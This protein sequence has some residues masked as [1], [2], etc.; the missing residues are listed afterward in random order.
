MASAAPGNANPL[1]LKSLTHKELVQ[2]IA[3]H[4]TDERAWREF[5]QRYHRP[6]VLSVGKAVRIVG[7]PEGFG[8]VEDLAQEVYKK[9]IEKN[10]H[11]LHVFKSEQEDGI[12]MYLKVIAIRVVLSDI[13]RKKAKKRPPPN[14][15]PPEGFDPPDDNWLREMEL[16]DLVDDVDLC[17]KKILQDSR[18]AERDMLLMSFF[19]YEQLR[20]AEIVSAL[21]LELSAKRVA[22]IIDDLLK[23]LRPCLAA[24]RKK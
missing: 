19:L 8:I 5:Y 2:F 20:P 18:H 22:N 7:H 11:A 16:D 15:P 13:A 3:Q 23:E 1:N 17:L 14:P 10:C 24:L 21:H 9:L 6:I 4:S 12:F